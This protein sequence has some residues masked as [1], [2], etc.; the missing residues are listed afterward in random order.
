[1][2]TLLECFEKLKKLPLAKTIIIKYEDDLAKIKFPYYMKVSLAEHKLEK[3]AVLKIENIEE[4]KSN[5]SNLKKQFQK[6]PIIIQ[7]QIQGVEMI[8]GLKEDKIFEKLLLIGFG[9]TNAEILKDIQFLAIPASKE[10]ILEAVS[11]LKLYDTLHKRKK[12]AIDKFIDLAYEVS[13]LNFKELDLNPVILT[14]DKAVIVD[15]RGRI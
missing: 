6:N 8:I 14:E 13:K 12:Y 11:S 9:G 3:K 2:L 7:E 15:A 10:E 1:M 5:Y 4:A